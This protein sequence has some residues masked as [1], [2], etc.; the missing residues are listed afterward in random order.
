[1]TTKRCI[2]SSKKMSA[3]LWFNGSFALCAL[4]KPICKNRTTSMNNRISTF[5]PKVKHSWQNTS[6]KEWSKAFHL[7]SPII[8]INHKK[9]PSIDGFS[10]ITEFGAYANTSFTKSA[11][12]WSWTAECTLRP[13]SSMR[14]LASSALVPWRRTMIGTGISPMFL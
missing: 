8:N 2:F 4:A 14:R 10:N 5:C 9:K 3:L 1:M 7:I 12:S 13:D 11:A 6:N